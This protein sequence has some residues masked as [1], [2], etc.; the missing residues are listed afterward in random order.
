[1]VRSSRTRAVVLTIVACLARAAVASAAP[2]TV[3]STL[4]AVDAT[5]GDGSCMTAGGVCTLR[6]AIQE[7][8]ALAGADVITVPAG[9][10]DL[11]LTG[12]NEDSAATGDLDI[13]ESVTINGAGATS[14]IIDGQHSDRI[15]DIFDT[16]GNVAI[17]G[18]TVRNGFSGI[19]NLAGG[20][21]NTAV[22]TL[23]QSR[24]ES[25]EGR[26]GGGGILN[27]NDLTAT[28]VT[29]IGNVTNG[30]GAGFYNTG[31]ATL[32]RVTVSGNTSA[33]A[34]GGI[35]NDGTLTLINTT[36]SGNTA[37]TDGGGLYNLLMATLQNAT[38]AANGAN[39]GGG[40]FDPGD[41]TFTN[42]IVADSVS[43]DSC[44]V[45]GTVTSMGSNL[46]SDATCSFTGAGDLSGVAPLLGSLA[47]NGGPTQ[48]HTLLAGSP[49][50][51]AGSSCP[52]P[53]TDQRG[54]TRPLDG[55]GDG[56]AVC[57]I[58]AVEVAFQPS[59]STTT[60]S[61]TLPT[62]TIDTPLAGTKLLLT[63]NAAN[64]S[65]RKLLVIAKDK[66]VSVPSGAD[67]P[68]TAGAELR[69]VTANGDGFDATYALPAAGWRTKG[70]P[71]KI[72]GHQYRDPNLANGP[73][74]V[75]VVRNGKLLKVTGRGSKL[76]H[77]LGRDPNP[78]LVVLTIGTSR[79]CTSF[80][81]PKPKFAAG[82]RFVA[83]GAPRP[84]SCDVPLQ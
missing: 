77:T 42:T 27:D 72:K 36:L 54:T 70:R 8:N 15:F 59:T 50:I 38:V 83:H 64:P 39:R 61:T 73:I 23:S 30:Q 52:P 29:L 37:T 71:G 55:N 5:P 40:I 6:A 84:S 76:T 66:A 81:G 57:D 43:G 25:S 46:D 62:N 78:V 3:N 16:A 65:K 82:K 34:A 12:P 32:E 63:D 56:S 14:T 53:A 69:V 28:D 79:Q 19:G 24:V 4:D 60:T 17:Q 75:V 1:M 11:T 68:E 74:A 44:N 26:L 51:D 67:A 20:I 41:A 45:G 31:T 9:T 33:A 48:T 13:Q 21:W 47:D 2:F 49:A 22:L 35:E 7:A 10:Y 58:G 80:G 18:V